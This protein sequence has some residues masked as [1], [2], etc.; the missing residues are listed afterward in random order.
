MKKSIS[1]KTKEIIEKELD[2]M[3]HIRSLMELTRLGARMMLQVALEEELKAFLGRDCYER[4]EN[5]KGSR[6]RTKPRTIK[7]G[8]GDIHIQMP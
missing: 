2:E 7:I 4:R 3:N 5:Q 6:S 1:K 8:C